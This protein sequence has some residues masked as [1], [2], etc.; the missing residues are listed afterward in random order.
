MDEPS[1]LVNFDPHNPASGAESAAG[2]KPRATPWA[3]EFH[4]CALKGRRGP[5]RPFRAEHVLG[6]VPGAL[7]RAGM[8]RAVGTS[9]WR[10]IRLGENCYKK[11]SD[12]ADNLIGSSFQV[13]LQMFYSV[14][15]FCSS[16]IPTSV[17]TDS[18]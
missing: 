4:R 1:R 11:I 6:H 5:I 18:G 17:R 12:R 13:A 7:P 14:R 15:K 8:L 3:W 10:N 2:F 16:C 9:S